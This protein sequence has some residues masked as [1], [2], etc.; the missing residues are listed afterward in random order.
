[1]KLFSDVRDRIALSTLQ[2]VFFWIN[3]ARRLT[4]A[5][6]MRTEKAKA[7]VGLGKNKREDALADL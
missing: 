7:S 2:A 4:S 1:M 5:H 3:A 6:A